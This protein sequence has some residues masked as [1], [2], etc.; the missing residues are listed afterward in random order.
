MGRATV[1]SEPKGFDG[2]LVE[3]LLRPLPLDATAGVE[4]EEGREPSSDGGRENQGALG[5]RGEA[6]DDHGDRRLFYGQC[7]GVIACNFD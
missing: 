4:A 5:D 2:V 6:G 1:N 7:G 3:G